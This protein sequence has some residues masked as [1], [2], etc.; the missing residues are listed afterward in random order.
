MPAKTQKLLIHLDL[1]RPQS[2]PEKLPVKFLRLFLSSGRYI[3]IFVEALVLMAFIIRFKLDADLA[4]KKEAIEQEVPFIES[5]KPYEILIR[6]TQLKLSTIAAFH[7]DS[8]DYP[9]ILKKI[10]DQTPLGIKIIS[11]NLKKD[12]GKIVVIINAQA[13][14]NS[15]LSNFITGLNQDKYFSQ[16]TLSSLGLEQSVIRFVI[17]VEVTTQKGVAKS[18]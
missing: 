8:Y 16:V 6:Q 2:S 12:V 7:T 10:A 14:T 1:L 9:Q 11:I 4:N 3:L 15:E 5:L 17:N 13:Q 18:L